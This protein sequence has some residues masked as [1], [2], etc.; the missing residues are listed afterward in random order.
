M[1][2][3]RPIRDA[4][5]SLENQINELEKAQ[6]EQIARL[7]RIIEISRVLNS[8]LELQPLL[9]DI[10]RAASELTST[11][12]SSVLLL[13]SKSGDLFFEAATG[14]K[15]YEV[16]RIAVPKE[17][18]AGWIVEHNEPVVINDVSQDTR[19]SQKVDEESG[20]VTRSIM[21]V[22]LF[23]KDR[24]IGALEVLNK[25]N[26]KPF[27]EDELNL[28]STLASQ[29]AVAIEKARLFQQSDQIADVV[30]E[31]RTPLTSIVG[32][33]KLLLTTQ[34]DEK[35][36]KQ[37]VEVINREAM[38]LGGMVN[39]FLDL[40]RLE[41]GRARLTYVPVDM[42]KVIEETVAVI[43][44]QAEERGLELLVDVPPT[45]PPITGD[46]KRMQ[47]VMLNLASNAVKYNREGGSIRIVAEASEESLKIAV[48]DTGRGVRPEDMDKL[49]DKFRRIE[50]SEGSAKGTGLGLPI[51]KQLI[52]LHEGEMQVTSEWGEGSTFAFTLPI[53]V[54]QE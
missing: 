20:F 37:F 18:I 12:V 17:S 10:I 19:W 41:S 48:K 26:E 53:A 22:P 46:E 25:R 5:T 6:R 30:H 28:L 45:L 42:K 44:P 1:E 52:E 49:F 47:Q 7:E 15:K 29:A 9:Q 14:I 32:Y 43:R 13:D 39:D 51:T 24:V 3:R 33:S 31:L 11:E 2:E 36:T 34:L 4:L 50:E 8:R 35:T 54:K 40:A 27:T 38:R 16:E 21:G 23:V